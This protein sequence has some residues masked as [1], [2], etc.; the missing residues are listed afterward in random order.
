MRWIVDDCVK[1]VEREIR[2]GHRYDIIIMDPPSYGRGPSGEI[3]KLE[4]KIYSFVE[5]CTGV[6]SEDALMVLVNSYTTGLSP[7]VMQ[8]IL[9]AVVNPRFGGEVRPMKSPSG[10]CSQMALPCGATAICAGPRAGMIES[11]DDNA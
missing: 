4:D 3:W 10:L 5:L 1:F 11:K 6:L 7:A 8:Y 2:R 9:G